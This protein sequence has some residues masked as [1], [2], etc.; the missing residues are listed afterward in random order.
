M[1]AFEIPLTYPDYFWKG[2]LDI[3]HFTVIGVLCYDSEA[4]AK[5]NSTNLVIIRLIE[6]TV[7]HLIRIWE[8]IRKIPNEF[9][10]DIL[11]K[12]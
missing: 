7:E 9:R 2:V 6:I 12:Q 10:R 11:V 3:Q 8:Y 5:G 4:L 1:S